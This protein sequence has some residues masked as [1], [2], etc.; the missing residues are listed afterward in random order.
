[1]QKSKLTVAIGTEV[2]SRNS[3]MQSLDQNVA[4]R[5]DGSQ[6]RKYDRSHVE[7][8]LTELLHDRNHFFAEPAFGFGGFIGE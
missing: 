5:S 2:Y 3:P 7:R 1:M 4:D 8:G 6:R